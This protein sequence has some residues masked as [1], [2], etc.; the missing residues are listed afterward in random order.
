VAKKVL[1]IDE[2]ALF[3]NYLKEKLESHGVAAVVGVNGLDGLVKM[4]N[5]MPDLIVMDYY[6]SRKSSMEILKE[7]KANRNIMDIPVIMLAPKVDRGHVLE[8]AG[9]NVRKILSKPVKME[10]LLEIISELIGQKIEVDRSPCIVEAHFNEDILFIEIARGLNA[11]KV[12]LL[13]YKMVELLELYEVRV[14]RV[15]LMMASIELPE[16]H[17]P[18]LKRLFDVVMEYG[19]PNPRL[20][21]VLTTNDRVKA[22]VQGSTDYNSISVFAS[23]EDAMDELVGLK[24]DSIAHDE[25]AQKK[26]LTSSKPKKEKGEEIQLRYDGESPAGEEEEDASR[27]PRGV[28]ASE[29]QVAVVD[30]DFVIQELVKT[31]FSETH[32]KITTY[33]DGKDFL[34]DEPNRTFDLIF[35]DLMMPQFNGFQV[36]QYLKDKKRDVPVIVFSALS[37]KETI[38]KAV[39]FGVKSYLIKPLKPQQLMRK[40]TEVLSTS[41]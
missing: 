15:L 28:F 4:R 8:M 31:V 3:R 34:L 30:D 39:G 11:E 23:L 5:E 10:G 40:A 12:E 13:G 19:Q 27:A 26:L 21:K 37:K 16:E 7:K 6:L 32:W 35:L 41:F 9:M 14:P 17:V 1:I 22:F 36:L 18:K 29:A 33:N 24:A 25:V 2:S 38:V 20:I